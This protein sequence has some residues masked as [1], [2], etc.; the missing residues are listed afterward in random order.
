MKWPQKL[1]L[2]AYKVQYFFISK[3]YRNYAEFSMKWQKLL[4]RTWRQKD[5]G[6]GK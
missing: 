5:I 6:F 3:I 2:E 4:A 1:K